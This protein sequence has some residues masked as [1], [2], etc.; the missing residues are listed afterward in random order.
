M[1]RL[2]LWISIGVVAVT[3]ITSAGL[4]WRKHRVEKVE[5]KA[6]LAKTVS[7][8]DVWLGGPYY[9]SYERCPEALVKSL[10]NEEDVGKGFQLRAYL[11]HGWPP[12]FLVVKFRVTTGEIIARRIETS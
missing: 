3:C 8:L 11:L 2:L 4:Y 6:L 12:T 5:H 1:K 10:V 9:A 7:E